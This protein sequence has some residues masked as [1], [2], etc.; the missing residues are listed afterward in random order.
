MST[1]CTRADI[2]ALAGIGNVAKWGDLEGHGDATEITARI[3]RAIA[4]ASDA[5][6]SRLLGG[7]YDIADILDT[8]S[9]PTI[10]EDVC[11][12]LSAAWLEE[13]RRLGASEDT[14]KLETAHFRKDAML[15]IR[16]LRA[17]KVR[18]VGLTPKTG[19]PEK[20]TDPDEEDWFV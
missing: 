18:I 6:D 10:I 11:A 5:L 19:V 14:E 9:T 20:V 1:Y 13:S 4:V 7:P 17:G 2:E 8:P 3:T 15:T 12:K 16:E